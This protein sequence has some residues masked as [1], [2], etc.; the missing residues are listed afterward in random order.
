MLLEESDEYMKEVKEL[1]ELTDSL[2]FLLFF[3]FLFTFS[4]SLGFSALCRFPLFFFLLGEKWQ[5]LCKHLPS[6][7]NLCF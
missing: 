4:L 1:V 3:S 7:Y 2:S 5:E 6:L